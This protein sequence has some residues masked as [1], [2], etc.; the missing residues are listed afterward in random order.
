MASSTA[1]ALRSPLP[2][3]HIRRGNVFNSH[4]VASSATTD[5]AP[6]LPFQ[7]QH[8]RTQRP[9]SPP[10]TVCAAASTCCVHGGDVLRRYPDSPTATAPTYPL[11]LGPRQQR[12]PPWPGHVH[13]GDILC[14][15]TTAVPQTPRVS[16]AATSTG[17]TTAAADPAPPRPPRPCSERHPRAGTSHVHRGDE[18]AP[19]PA[20]PAGGLVC[21]DNAP[22]SSR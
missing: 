3:S 18:T 17:A 1:V 8:P 5:P 11:P 20:P 15:H 16:C 14:G 12:Y 19:A 13:R 22:R 10:S 6:P 2:R 9:P 21:N 7:P 4:T